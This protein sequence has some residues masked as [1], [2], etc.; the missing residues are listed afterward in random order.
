MQCW[1][2]LIT[3]MICIDEIMVPEAVDCFN[4]INL[5]SKRI[6]RTIDLILN[7]AELQ[8]GHYQ[9]R[10]H[11]I[12]LDTEILHKLYKERFLSASQRGLEFMYNC[13]LNDPKI[14]ADDY[15]TTQIFANLI[16]NAIKYTKKGKVEILLTKN[17]NGNIIVEIKDTGIGIAKEFLPRLFD[18]FTQEEQGYK[19]SFEGNGLGLV[20]VKRY[21]EINY[22]HLEVE[23]P[24]KM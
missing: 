18:A 24:R 10:F 3:S 9:P 7:A 17:R 21:C 14:L 5:A 11:Q 13:E 23:S 19:R 6:I 15:S 20:I 12:D 1:V 8:T 2:M 4:G 22:A 16:D